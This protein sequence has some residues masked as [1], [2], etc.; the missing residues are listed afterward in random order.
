MKSAEDFLLLVLNAPAIVAD[1][2]IQSLNPVES[3]RELARLIVVSSIT[4]PDFLIKIK[5]VQIWLS[6]HPVDEP[7]EPMDGSSSVSQTLVIIPVDQVYLFS[8]ER[9]AHQLLWSCTINTRGR[10][11]A[12]I[13][14][15]LHMD[16]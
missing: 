9:L 13:P 1:E 3:A 16:I 8:S 6:H 5:Q 2:N 11:G 15:D 7:S 14:C 4:L 10:I 12:N